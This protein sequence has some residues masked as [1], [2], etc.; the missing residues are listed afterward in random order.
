M[1]FKNVEVPDELIKQMAGFGLLIVP[2]RYIAIRSFA[3]GL[4]AGLF[5]VIG[6]LFAVSITLGIKWQPVA[7]SWF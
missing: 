2:R 3:L 1:R 5:T 4:W 7:A 6:V